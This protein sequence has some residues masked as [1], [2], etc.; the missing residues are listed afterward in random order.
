MSKRRPVAVS[1]VRD[2]EVRVRVRVRVPVR[3][4]GSC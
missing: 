2:C 1:G 4:R 3:V